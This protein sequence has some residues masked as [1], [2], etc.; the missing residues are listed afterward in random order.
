M[1]IQEQRI[2]RLE[3]DVSSVFFFG[4]R[5][6]V[7]DKLTALE[8][9]FAHL[10]V[11]HTSGYE[12]RTQ[13]IDRLGTHTVQTYALLKSLGIVFTSGVQHR[14]CIDQTTQGNT[15]AIVAHRNTQII[16]Y[17]NVDTLT[18]S[19]FKFIDGIVYHFFQKHINSV[20]RLR[21]I[22]QAANVH[23]RTHTHVLHIAQMTDVLFCI[24]Y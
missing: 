3:E 21:T 5:C 10:S 18:D 17:G 20:F 15:T 23:T 24:R 1:V 7:R 8:Y 11:S 16:F 22:S 6:V 9:R 14:Y 12:T 19:H 13:G 4:S 2:V